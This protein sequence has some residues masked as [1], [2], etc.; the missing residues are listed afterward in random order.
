MADTTKSGV[1]QLEN[2]ITAIGSG[3]LFGHGFNNT[4]IYF[5]EA[6]T[7]FIFAVFASNF[8]LIGSLLL[9]LLIAFFD[10][11]LILTAMKSNSNINKYIIII[12]NKFL[13]TKT[14]FVWFFVLPLNYNM[15]KINMLCLLYNFYLKS[16]DIKN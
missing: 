1:Y 16:I 14:R 7:D 4:P 2:G 6:Q 9:L 12:K 8:G 11:K 3:G 5:P 15:P 10:I 13:K